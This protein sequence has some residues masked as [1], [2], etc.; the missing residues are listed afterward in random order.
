MFSANNE[1]EPQAPASDRSICSPVMKNAVTVL[2]R[3]R[4][5]RIV[6]KLATPSQHQRRFAA[7]AVVHA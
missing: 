1:T 2:V 5:Q 6:V 3:K 4:T 7:V